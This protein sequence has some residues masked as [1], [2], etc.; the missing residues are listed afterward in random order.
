[1]N[2]FPGPKYGLPGYKESHNWEASDVDVFSPIILSEN[3]YEA[4]YGASRNVTGMGREFIQLDWVKQ[5]EENLPP[6]CPQGK[7]K[8]SLNQYATNNPS[9]TTVSDA[10]GNEVQAT[11]MQLLEGFLS[12]GIYEGKTGKLGAMIGDTSAPAGS[13]PQTITIASDNNALSGNDLSTGLCSLRPELTYSYTF[14][15]TLTDK[16][17]N[18][19]NVMQF[20]S[21][22]NPAPSESL[23]TF[24][25]DVEAD[26]TNLIFS[27]AQSD[28]PSGWNCTSLPGTTSV[29]KPGTLE[30][31]QAVFVALVVEKFHA[32]SS[33]LI[34]YLDGD[35]A[36]EKDNGMGTTQEPDA[37]AMLYISGTSG[38]FAAAKGTVNM[39]DRKSV[40]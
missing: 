15:L 28:Y 9:A 30:F 37:S 25:L 3:Y 10:E 17:A 31:N 5:L 6:N 21:S 11:C 24:S 29:T 1:M 33:K 32:A 38:G 4:M 23:P 27:V 12:S 19:T 16:D 36:C 13:D 34:L 18:P 2:N 35:Q 8:W 26:T 7:A 22:A 39:I 14:W 40:V 20:V